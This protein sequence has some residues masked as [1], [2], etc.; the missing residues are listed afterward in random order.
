MTS[1]TVQTTTRRNGNLMDASAQ[2]GSRAPDERWDSLE[3]LREF[4]H[5][6]RVSSHEATVPIDGIEIIPHGQALALRGKKTG[7][8]ADFTNYSFGQLCSRVGAPASYLGK[9]DPAR[10]AANLNV[11]I[12]TR[13]EAIDRDFRLLISRRQASDQSP[14]TLRAMLTSVYDRVW[15]VT[16]IDR[17]IDARASGWRVP[18]ARPAFPGQPGTRLATAED[19]LRNVMPGLGIR[20]GDPIA[21]A[22]IYG[23]DRDM[24]VFV[25]N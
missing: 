13:A 18:P 2:W 7:A 17:L 22:G 4:K 20:V 14:L 23:S 11:D 15:D 3:S 24:F 16:V 10:A 5:E 6:Q 25:V 8:V 1:I 21:P 12:E 9:M 19:V